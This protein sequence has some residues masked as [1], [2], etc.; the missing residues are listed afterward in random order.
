MELCCLLV[1]MFLLVV[2]ECFHQIH[3]LCT[4][5]KQQQTVLMVEEFN[6]YNV[7]TAPIKSKYI[8]S[9]NTLIQGGCKIFRHS[10]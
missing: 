5:A 9:P 3:Y 6:F 7:N 8:Q 1:M 10:S 4:K 2:Y